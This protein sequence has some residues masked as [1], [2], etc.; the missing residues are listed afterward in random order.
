M[1]IL[2]EHE[3]ITL[4]SLPPN[5][6]NSNINLE[7]F[8]WIRGFLISPFKLN[9]FDLRNFNYINFYNIHIY[10]SNVL[11]F[12]RF[13]FDDTSVIIL[14]I[15]YYVDETKFTFNICKKLCE[16]L[17]S[18]YENFFEYLN[19]IGGRYLIIFKK[20]NE[21]RILNDPHALRTVFFHKI[22]SIC[23]SHIELL[24]L[25]VHENILDTV[26]CTHAR[27]KFS[28]ELPGNFTK[29]KNIYFLPGNFYYSIKQ[30]TIKRF[31]PTKK[32]FY[33]SIFEARTKI[34]KKYYNQIKNLSSY[35]N[36]VMSLT[37]G[38]DSQVSLYSANNL[39]NNIFYFTESRDND[40]KEAKKNVEKFNLNWIGIDTKDFH[41]ENN[42]FFI[43][44]KN[45]LNK[46]AYPPPH[47][48]FIAMSIF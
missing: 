28:Y 31:W 38:K 45:L 14:G 27:Y 48:F 7:D 6:F 19:F 1:P 41:V 13:D 37:G 46:H 12:K 20:E 23:A 29:Y 10:Y 4:S 21:I 35:Y 5:L 8:L 42:K 18:S 44:F 22:S 17:K 25:F 32:R 47:K 39:M 36:I 16:N 11:E 40:I 34:L 3:G 33:G 15:S 26:N 9:N 43:E 24:N 30:K 2:S